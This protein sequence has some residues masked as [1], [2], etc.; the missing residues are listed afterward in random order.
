MAMP[1]KFSEAQEVEIV[2]LYQDEGLTSNDIAQRMQCHGLTVRNVLK[3]RGIARRNPGTYHRHDLGL[4]KADAAAEV[5]RQ[6]R[7]DGLTLRQLADQYGCSLKAIRSALTRAGMTDRRGNR[8]QFTEDD[9]TYIRSAASRNQ[10]QSSIADA[11]G[12]SQGTISN[13]MREIEIETQFHAKGSM[14]GSRKG[15]RWQRSDGYVQVRVE[16]D[17]PFYDAMVG[18]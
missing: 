8:H 5:A 2:R 7:E 4:F 16:R 15:G 6:Y 3:R 1:M 18:R 13:V 9:L 11:L 14:H 17:H 12:V 10:S